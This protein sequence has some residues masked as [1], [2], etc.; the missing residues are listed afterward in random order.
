MLGYLFLEIPWRKESIIKKA[1][2]P[3]KIEK[4]NVSCLLDHR[5]PSLRIVDLQ[6]TYG[7]EIE[8]LNFK[9]TINKSGCLVFASSHQV[10]RY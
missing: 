2:E 6:I 4:E 8:V 1:L 3:G 9:C 7:T 10:G 5:C